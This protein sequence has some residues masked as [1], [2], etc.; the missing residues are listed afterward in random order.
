MAEN[1]VAEKFAV[2]SFNKTKCTYICHLH[3]GGAWVTHYTCNEHVEANDTH[4]PTDAQMRFLKTK[5]HMCTN[6]AYKIYP[7]A[8]WLSWP[9]SCAVRCRF[10]SREHELSI[11]WKFEFSCWHDATACGLACCTPKTMLTIYA[12]SVSEKTELNGGQRE[13]S[14]LR[15]LEQDGRWRKLVSWRRWWWQSA[16][17]T[18]CVWFRYPGK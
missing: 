13:P 6:Y 1:V 9:L 4:S 2:T 5:S 8:G 10:V 12:F 18:E 7:S 16:R 15:V 17:N 14:W 3:I 11:C